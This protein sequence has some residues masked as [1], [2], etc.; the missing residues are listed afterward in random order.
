MRPA[1]TSVDRG[2][3]VRAGIVLLV[4]AGASILRHPLF[5]STAGLVQG[6]VLVAVLLTV[7]IRE[8]R[9]RI[10]VVST[11]WYRPMVVTIVLLAVVWIGGDLVMMSAMGSSEGY[12]GGANRLTLSGAVGTVGAMLAPSQAGSMRPVISYA[13]MGCVLLLAIILVE[14]FVHGVVYSLL[15]ALAGRLAAILGASVL[16]VILLWPIPS[17]GWLAVTATGGVGLLLGV[18]RWTSGS[19]V[20]AILA[21]VVS[22]GKIVGVWLPLFL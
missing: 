18:S 1:A 9:R 14:L 8:W 7:V 3:W 21:Q 6:L 4:L 22:V 5:A 17:E 16:Y 13:L 19:V 10:P 15:D 20:P 12:A 11:P 2:E